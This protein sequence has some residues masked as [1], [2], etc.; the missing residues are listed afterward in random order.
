MQRRID[1]LDA[2][3]NVTVTGGLEKLQMRVGTGKAMSVSLTFI[4]DEESIIQLGEKKVRLS[5]AIKG[6]TAYIKAFDRT[7][8]LTVMDPVEQAADESGT[9]GNTVRAP[10]PGM[11][12][13]VDI[14]VISGGAT[15]VAG[16]CDQ[17]QS[18]KTLQST[19]DR[20][21]RDFG[22]LSGDDLEYLVGGGVIV[23]AEN[24]P[25]NRPF[26]DCAA[27][28]LLPADSAEGVHAFDLD[29]FIQIAASESFR[30]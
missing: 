22:I 5:M 13:K 23:E 11:V 10:R 26:L 6:E 2:H 27:K 16:L 24:G 9:P 19:I 18:G 29:G 3:Y 30:S 15:R 25:E 14:A 20:G 21:P 12:V 28:P 8:A 4:N 1:L 17:P 7:L